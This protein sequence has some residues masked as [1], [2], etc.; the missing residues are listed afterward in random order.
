MGA[1]EQ[2]VRKQCEIALA[3]CDHRPK[4]VGIETRAGLIDS[5]EVGSSAQP[6]PWAAFFI[7]KGRDGSGNVGRDSGAGGHS[8]GEREAADRGRVS[9]LQGAG[10]VSGTLLYGAGATV[11]IE[12]REAVWT[13]GLPEARNTSSHESLRRFGLSGAS[14]SPW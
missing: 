11:G 5:T 7:G 3:G 4:R 6:R 9:Y 2:G 14:V 13:I 10:R 12:G 1:A 8:S